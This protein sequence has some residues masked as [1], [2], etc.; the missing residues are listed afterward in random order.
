MTYITVNILVNTGSIDTHQGLLFVRKFTN[1]KYRLP[2]IFG[3]YF[4]L[5]STVH[6]HDTR[7]SD[8][9]HVTTGNRSITHKASTLWTNLPI[10][11]FVD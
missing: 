8:D 4:R 10:A 5:I 2:G 3:N 9:L 11:L 7:K 1:H 6:G